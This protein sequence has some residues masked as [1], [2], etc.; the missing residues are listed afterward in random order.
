MLGSR[1]SWK[2]IPSGYLSSSAW[3][4]TAASCCCA[5]FY[6][7]LSEAC[8]LQSLT[9]FQ[10]TSLILLPRWQPQLLGHLLIQ[11]F[12][13]K[14]RSFC[15]ALPISHLWDSQGLSWLMVPPWFYQLRAEFIG[16][17]GT[18]GSPQGTGTAG[19]KRRGLCRTHTL[20]IS[21]ISFTTM[22]TY[23]HWIFMTYVNKAFPEGL[24]ML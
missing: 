18:Q 6:C 23:L 19:A 2:I 15:I 20:G 14:Q 9:G 11:L 12:T 3:G 24:I 13:V 1:G 22:V 21:R 10:M 16:S 4:H 7:I 17:W 5:L 8:T